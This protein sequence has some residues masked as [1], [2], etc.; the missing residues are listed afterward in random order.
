MAAEQTAEAGAQARVPF[1]Q[2]LDLAGIAQHW[3]YACAYPHLAWDLTALG[4][5]DGGAPC[6]ES[7]NGQLLLSLQLAPH[8]SLHFSLSRPEPVNTFTQQLIAQGLPSGL[9]LSSAFRE[10]RSISSPVAAGV[11]RSPSISA[12]PAVPVPL[13][14][15]NS[16]SGP[17]FP[18]SQ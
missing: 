16:A 9:A 17:S 10:F 8:Y 13:P 2:A 15:M 14:S 3:A 6:W 18:P 4:W 7:N 11:P 12:F 1:A 5:M